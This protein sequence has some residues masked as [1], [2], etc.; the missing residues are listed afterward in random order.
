MSKDQTAV[1]K[2]AFWKRLRKNWDLQLLAI[3]GIVLIL[4]FSYLPMAGL[5]MAFQN[6]NVFKGLAGF[7]ESPW[8][9]F[10]NFIDFF[11]APEFT[12]VM[13]NTLVISALKFV[14]CFPAPILLALMLN[15][16]LN[17]R[18]K[19]IIQT[20]TYMP[21]FLSWVV[22][23]GFVFSLFGAEGGIVNDFLQALG[24]IDKPVGWLVSEEYFWGIL[25]ITNVW[26][27][28]GYSAIIY[29]AAMAGIDPAYYEA[30]SIDGAT[31]LQKIFRITLPCIMP[32]II[33]LLVMQIGNILNAGFDDVF[34]LTNNGKNYALNNV[35]QTID[36]YVYQ[37]GILKQ[38][39]SYAAAVG[40]FK[41]VFNVIF[42]V[43]A[44]KIAKKANGSSIW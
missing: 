19:K 33:V 43:M 27:F 28:S 1:Q 24:L 38:R 8:V 41:S 42:L 13:T 20:I 2:K 37:R 9:G 12:S 14:I 34:L 18:F 16:L 3:P 25:V 17:M 35:G 32:V 11:N 40:M 5:V 4:I 31:K 21:Y 30:A 44:N 15:E 22:V 6:Y 26:K 36:T 23:S 39:Y 10:K 7:V 29:L